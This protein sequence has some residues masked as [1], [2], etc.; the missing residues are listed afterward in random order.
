VDETTFAF[1]EDF[2]CARAGAVA[3]FEPA[4]SSNTVVTRLT[5]FATYAYLHT[6]PAT[7][8]YRLPDNCRPQ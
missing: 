7:L 1:P 6:Y 2:A 8:M 5:L 4:R 3:R